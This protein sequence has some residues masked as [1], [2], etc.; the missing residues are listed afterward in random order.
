MNCIPPRKYKNNASLRQHKRT[1]HGDKHNTIDPDIEDTGSE[2]S[3]HESDNSAID[4]LG[5]ES[6]DSYGTGDEAKDTS[7]NQN[8]SLTD[9]SKADSDEGYG[10]KPARRAIRDKG[11]G[12]WKRK[13]R[14]SCRRYYPYQSN[15][16]NTRNLQPID[17]AKLMKLLCKSLLNGIIPMEDQHVAT[18][19][20]HA[21]FVRKVAHG[22]IK[23]TK[24]AIQDGGSII[25]TVL[26]TVLP[27]IS[28]LIN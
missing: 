2:Q 20:P 21:E 22:K 14:V 5:S 3:D 26:K 28:A 23:E 18:L 11:P 24:E 8:E 6:S 1:F 19:K 9:D 12:K 13:R 27:I 7:R 17:H 10:N 15:R 16:S 25:Q 4:Q